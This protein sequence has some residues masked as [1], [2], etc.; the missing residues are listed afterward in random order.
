MKKAKTS[1][2]KHLN[3]IL[4]R[5]LILYFALI[6]V[7]YIQQRSFIYFPDKTKPQIDFSFQ[8]KPT[9]TSILTKDGL[10]LEGWFFPPTAPQAKI[11]LFFH[12]NGGNISHRLY[13]VAPYLAQNYGILLAEYRG[14]G[15]NAGVPTEEGLYEDARAY[16]A[17]L[18]QKGYKPED[19]IFYGESL[20][21]GV[22]VQL[23]TEQKPAALILETPYAKLSE[24]AQKTYFFIPFIE[25]LMHDKYASIDKISD[26]PS[27]KLFLLAKQ[28]EVVG[29]Q[30]GLDLYEKTAPQKTL[31]IF[32]SA[33]HNTLYQYG[34]EKTVIEFLSTLSKKS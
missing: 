29:F 30:T 14:Y 28:D 33:N 6:A 24:P 13:K 20:G 8:I 4:F 15:G 17:W 10:P 16:Y 2:P 32:E 18:L 23:A 7:L 3:W 26:I 11:I 34:A 31:K 9:Q 1:L 19:I 12:G 21:T 5:G 27:P 22:A 25:L